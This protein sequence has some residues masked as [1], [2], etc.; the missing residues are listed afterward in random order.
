MRNT[1]LRSLLVVGALAACSSD[2]S[3]GPS[4]HTLQN[5]GYPGTG[6]R[7]QEGFVEGEAAAAIFPARSHDYVVTHV[8]FLF[9]GGG[10][11]KTITLTLY[12][13]S[14]G[15]E[16][17]APLHSADYEVTPSNDAMQDIDL[18]GDSV[19]VTEGQGLRVALNFHHDGVPSVAV[20]SGGIGD[21]RNAIHTTSGWAFAETL[22]VLGD[23]VIRA[24]IVEE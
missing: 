6:I 24:L 14:G 20:D 5:D 11:S 18:T 8:Q 7:F 21:D 16:P 3:S 1:L 15:A 10:T 23:F 13:D 22:G 17:G 9:G 19:V 4:M 2:G 12:A